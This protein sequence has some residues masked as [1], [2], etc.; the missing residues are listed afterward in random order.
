MTKKKGVV[1]TEPYKGVRDFYP[2]DMYIEE[3]LFETMRD[4]VE[5]FG[6]EEYATS[7]LEPSELYEG[8]TSEEIVQRANILIY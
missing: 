4:V 2:E 8:K 1:G 7:P 6:Y 3:Y 5:H